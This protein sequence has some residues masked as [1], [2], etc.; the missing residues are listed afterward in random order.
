M[1]EREGKKSK[2]SRR[3]KEGP[4]FYNCQAQGFLGVAIKILQFIFF[5]TTFSLFSHL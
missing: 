3:N 1:V 5:T 4:V 2:K